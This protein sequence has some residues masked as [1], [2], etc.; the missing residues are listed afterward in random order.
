VAWAA[1]ALVLL[2]LL[3]YHHAPRTAFIG[4]DFWRIALN[5]RALGQGFQRSIA[6]VLPDRP[7][8]VATILLNHA[9]GGLDPSGYKVLSLALHVA[10]GLVFFALLLRLQRRFHGAT[11]VVLPALVAA[12]FLVH[13]LNTQAVLSAIQRGVILASLGGLG[14]IVFFLDHVATRR[15]SS[16]LLALL[17]Y[18]LAVLSKSFVVAV[19]AILLLYLRVAGE[20][21]RPLLGRFLPL[22]LVSALPVIPYRF[23]GVNRQEGAGVLAWH[24]YL[25]VQTRVVWTYLRLF[26]A[27][28]RLRFLYEFDPDPGLLRNL[29]WLA[30]A[31]HGALLAA[32]AFLVRRLPLAGFGILALYLAFLPE[33]GV[34]AIRHLAF[35]HRAY[36]PLLFFLLALFALLRSSP[37]AAR[38]AALPLLLAVALFSGLTSARVAAVDTFEKWALDTYRYQRHDRANNLELL[39]SLLV[40]GNPAAGARVARALAAQDPASPLYPLFQAVFTFQDDGPAVRRSTLERVRATLLRQ[41]PGEELDDLTARNFLLF[42]INSSTPFAPDAVAYQSALEP[43]YRRLLPRFLA[44][45]DFFQELIRLHQENLSQLVSHYETA[46]ASR[47]LAERELVQYVNALWQWSFYFPASAAE[48]AARGERLKQGHP[49]RAAVVDAAAEYYALLRR[50]LGKAPPP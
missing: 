35:E 33:S 40:A 9:L 32:A 22:L 37:R 46:L 36:F 48:V 49:E 50:T 16:Y 1:L 14:T 43:A 30:I 20:P 15:R 7:V 21:I 13:P 25:L 6:T 34:F 38:A 17:C 47:E 3:A 42:L 23:W 11:G 26:L 29:T 4:D 39:N 27:P 19:P 44:D 45:P 8:L 10:V 31:G 12:V 41:G 24:D 5:D 2:T 18:T 28:A